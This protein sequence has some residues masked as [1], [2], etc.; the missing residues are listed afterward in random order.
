[1]LVQFTL[2]NY[3]SVKD[4]VTFDL[5]ALNKVHEKTEHIIEKFD[6]KI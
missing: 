1:M 4:S 5:Q 3:R 6:D 2:E